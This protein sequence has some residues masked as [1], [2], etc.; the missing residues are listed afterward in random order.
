[1]IGDDMQILYPRLRGADAILLASP[2]YWFTFSAQLKLC[3]DRWYALQVPGGNELGG[4]QFGIALT[5]GDSNLQ[6]SGGINAIHTF[7]SMFGYI[8]AD[9]AGIV[10]GSAHKPG[11]I[12]KQPGLMAE[13]FQLGVK[14]AK[15][16]NQK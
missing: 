10:H 9:I 3:I 6:N 13:A 4:K 16:A 14:L 7:E 11:E 12:E 8:Q 2:V 15:A 5:Y 1:M